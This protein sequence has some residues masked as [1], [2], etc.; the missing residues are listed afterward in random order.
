MS[1]SDSLDQGTGTAPSIADTAWIAPSADVV[2]DVT[3]GPHA[4]VWYG[5]ILRGDIA[6]IHIGPESNIQ[7]LTVVHVDHDLPAVIGARVGV[8]HRAI[9]HGCEIEDDCLIGMGAVIL[10]GAVIGEGS[11]IG[12]GALVTEGARI[13]SGS[14]VIGLPGRVVR[15]VDDDL[16]ARTR[17]TIENYRALKD[18]HRSGRWR[19]Q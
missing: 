13:P 14:L 12:A 9:I 11:V 4:S 1:G 19:P 18:E 2:G 5:C 8:G 10:S 16:R 6:P 17:R 15:P 3:I 7:D